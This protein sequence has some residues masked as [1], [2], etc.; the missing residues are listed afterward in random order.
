MLVMYFCFRSLNQIDSMSCMN[1][2]DSKIDQTS[3]MFSKPSKSSSL[4]ISPLP[5]EM[6]TGDSLFDLGGPWRS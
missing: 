5:L 6:S 4:Q 1:Q 2:N 3:G